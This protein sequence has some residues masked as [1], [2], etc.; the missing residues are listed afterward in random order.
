MAAST[1]A[2]KLRKCVS[3]PR[4]E[5]APAGTRRAAVAVLLAS[6]AGGEEHVLFIQRAVNPRD[7]W[8]GDVAFP[9]GKRDES[10][11]SDEDAAI[12]EVLEEVGI[13]VRDQGVWRRIGQIADDR[14]VRRGQSHRMIV[15][16]F[17]FEL[18]RP[19]PQLPESTPQR[20]EVDFAWWVPIAHLTPERLHMRRLPLVKY[21]LP[22]PICMVL[23]SLGT[24]GIGF[25]SLPLP[26][27]TVAAAE[28]PLWGLTLTLSSEVL[29]RAGLP[30]LVGPGAALP[31]FR[32]PFGLAGGTLGDNLVRMLLMARGKEQTLRRLLGTATALVGI[33]IAWYVQR[34][35]TKT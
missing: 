11:A 8:S 30:T 25:A 18:L 21:K 14:I 1:I 23:G 26:S 10:D 29:A 19:L 24:D 13:D 32:H 5:A 12:R 3:E 31:A 27:P 33:T 35:V 20:G 15:A 2:S 4:R 22:R 28:P 34:R 6:A 7:A 17:G 16:T 9:G